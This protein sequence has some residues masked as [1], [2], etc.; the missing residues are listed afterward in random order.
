MKG[1]TT[2]KAETMTNYY[3]QSAKTITCKESPS[4][5]LT[6][7]KY[8]SGE[9]FTSDIEDVKFWSKKAYAV[10]ALNGKASYGINVTIEEYTV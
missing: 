9:R 6:H 5:E 3:L 4:G 10:K 8:W 1:N 7:L 2:K